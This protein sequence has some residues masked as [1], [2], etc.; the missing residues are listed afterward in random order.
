MSKIPEAMLELLG[1]DADGKRAEQCLF[2]VIRA[3]EEAGIRDRA[4]G[5]A[6][7]RVTLGF[8][9][10]LGRKEGNFGWAND[11]LSTVGEALERRADAAHRRWVRR[12][13]KETGR[14]YREASCCLDLEIPAVDRAIDGRLQS[15]DTQGQA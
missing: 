11:V 12:F 7:G 5:R 2:A 6:V 1:A 15:L 13:M 14:L 3:L 9:S 8:C 4:I 10:E